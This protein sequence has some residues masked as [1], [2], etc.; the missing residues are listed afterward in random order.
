MM[1]LRKNQVGLSELKNEIQVSITETPPSID[2]LKNFMVKEWPRILEKYTTINFEDFPL[3]SDLVSDDPL[4]ILHNS[5]TLLIT[6]EDYL[7]RKTE[8]ILDEL[9]SGRLRPEKI[10][11]DSLK[12]YVKR[13]LDNS[14]E[15][16][17]LAELLTRNKDN[18]KSS[19]SGTAFISEYRAELARGSRFNYLKK[20]ESICELIQEDTIDLGESSTRQTSTIYSKFT[21]KQLGLLSQVIADSF[22]TGIGFTNLKKSKMDEVFLNNVESKNGAIKNIKAL[23]NSYMSLETSRNDIIVLKKYFKLLEETLDKLENEVM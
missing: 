23:S 7:D 8:L 3:S 10:Y 18:K 19:A 11:I 21:Q 6:L 9:A 5:V 2:N 12:R 13:S 20:L 14:D 15:P 4:T 22:N 1:Y 16:K 17:D